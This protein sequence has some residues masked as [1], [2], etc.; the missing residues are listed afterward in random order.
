MNPMLYLC[1]VF[2]LWAA[3]ILVNTAICLVIR[4]FK[5]SY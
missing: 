3:I 1:G 2:T 4:F 5:K